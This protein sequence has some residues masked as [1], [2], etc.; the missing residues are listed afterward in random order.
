M[1]NCTLLTWNQYILFYKRDNINRNRTAFSDSISKLICQHCMFFHQL[2]KQNILIKYIYHHLVYCESLHKLA[3]LISD[4]WIFDSGEDLKQWPL[5]SLSGISKAT[6]ATILGICD[7]LSWHLR[8]LLHENTQNTLLWYW[9][10]MVPGRRAMLCYHWETY[11]S[12]FKD[13]TFCRGMWVILTNK[14]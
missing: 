5:Q 4:Y 11:C 1:I 13:S 3:S 9:C 7:I 12:V 6:I 2:I 10:Q 8:I 14:T